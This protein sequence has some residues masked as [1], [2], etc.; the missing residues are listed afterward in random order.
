[1]TVRVTAQ[2]HEKILNVAE[3]LKCC[4]SDAMHVIMH[5]THWERLREHGPTFLAEFKSPKRV[6]VDTVSE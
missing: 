3:S 5:F 1:M 6:R 4:D 2:E